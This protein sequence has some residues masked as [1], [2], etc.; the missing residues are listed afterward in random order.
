MKWI[1]PME[2]IVS[3]KIKEDSAY[4][5]EIKWDGIRGMVYIR[6]GKLRIF[7]KKGNERTGFYPELEVLCRELGDE[8]LVLDG[9]IIVPDQN[10]IP[11]FYNSLMRERVRNP[12]R[13]P[14]YVN[15]YPITYMV[16]DILYHREKLLTGLPLNER[17]LLLEKVLNPIAGRSSSIFICKSYTDGR[18]LFQKMKEKNMEG[19]VSKR[20]D[21]RYIGGKKHDAWYK[22]KFIKKMLCIV[23][24]IQWKGKIPNS[25]VLGIKPAGNDR[26]VYT[27]KASIGLKQSDLMLIKEYST[28][29]QK[30]DCPFEAKESILTDSTGDSFTW[31]HPALTCWI[32]FLEMTNDGHFRHP[33]I[34]GFTSLPPEEADGKVLTE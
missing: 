16:F 18:D 34:T 10:G 19:I 2:P 4:I 26:L 24:G 6:D 22:T 31:L 30:E 32:S 23:G 21:S 20:I 25:L 17:K 11:S 28:Q 5:H 3:S 27:G 1:D 9:E 29:I 7:T 33:K 15:N 12:V 8:N 14:Y 13:L